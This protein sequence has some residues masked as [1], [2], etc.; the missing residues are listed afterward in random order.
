MAAQES[1]SFL[2]V[3]RFHGGILAGGTS[4]AFA[5]DSHHADRPAATQVKGHFSIGNPEPS[6]A[7]HSKDH[8]IHGTAA[9]L[10]RNRFDSEDSRLRR[11]WSGCA[12]LARMLAF[13]ESQTV[14]AYLDPPES[15]CQVKRPESN[16]KI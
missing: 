6:R 13:N 8:R 12:T 1:S 7:Q 4:R 5:G 15:R 10:S 11:T 2:E 14:L 3:E 16:Q 9:K